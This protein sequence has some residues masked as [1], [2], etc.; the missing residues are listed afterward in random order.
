MITPFSDSVK[1]TVPQRDTTYSTNGF[2]LNCLGYWPEVVHKL[3]EEAILEVRQ[4]PLDGGHIFFRRGGQWIQAR[5]LAATVF[6]GRTVVGSDRV[7]AERG[8]CRVKS[9]HIRHRRAV[10]PVGLNKSILNEGLS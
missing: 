7:A 8:L 5:S 3:K 1:Q 2:R 6:H 10:A 9:P 4:D